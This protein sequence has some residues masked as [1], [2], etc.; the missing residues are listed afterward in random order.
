MDLATA[1]RTPDTDGSAM[2]NKLETII[3]SDERGAW[4][5]EVQEAGRFKCANCGS[6]DRVKPRMVVPVEAGG[7]LVLGNGILL[8]RTCEL[9]LETAA[10]YAEP[11]KTKRPVNFWVS[12]KL[13]DRLN[14]ESE[15]TT[16]R[17]MAGLVR[18]LMTKYVSDPDRFD[19]LSQYQDAGTDVKVNVWVESDIYARFKELVDR[20]GQTVTDSLKGL[21]CLFENESAKLFDND[22]KKE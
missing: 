7:K 15:R 10:R 8:C 11:T 21:I 19:D 13:Y 9:T 12:R 1:G 16:F 4:E 18:F 2:G 22:N 5:K 14:D 6:D 17:S 20:R 3:G